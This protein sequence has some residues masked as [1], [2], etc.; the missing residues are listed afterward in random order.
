MHESLKKILGNIDVTGEEGIE[1]FC[2]LLMTVGGL[3]DSPKAH[4]RMDSYFARLKEL[5]KSSD[6]TPRVQFTVQVSSMA[7]ARPMFYLNSNFTQDLIELHERKWV[8]RD[9]VVTSTALPARSK[10]PEEHNDVYYGGFEGHSKG[11]GAEA[12]PR[13][14]TK[15]EANKKIVQ[16]VKELFSARNID[17]SEEYFNRLPCEHH[18]RLVGEVVWKAIQSKETDGKLVAD[19]FARAIEKRLCSIETFEKGFLLAAEVLDE[20]AIDDSKAPQIMAT[21]MKGAGLDKDLERRARIVQE[22]TNSGKLLEL[23]A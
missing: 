1:S 10:P 21:M 13:A 3:L 6:V 4:V 22:L 19:A 11:S 9:Q 5:G 14:M 12:V 2:R 16:D 20:I 8:P 18:Y 17:K 15:D 23:L 7:Y